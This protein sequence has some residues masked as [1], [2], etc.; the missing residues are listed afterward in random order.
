MGMVGDIL[1]DIQ[2]DI[3]ARQIQIIELIQD[4]A[5]SD[6]GSSASAW[7]YLCDPPTLLTS[8]ETTVPWHQPRFREVGDMGCFSH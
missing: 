1:R 3:V 4:S 5:E 7:Q 8:L 2:T 6:T